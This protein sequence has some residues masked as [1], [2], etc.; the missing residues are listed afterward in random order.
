MKITV[1]LGVSCRWS[2]KPAMKSLHDNYVCTQKVSVYT[3]DTVIPTQLQYAYIRNTEWEIFSCSEY[4]SKINYM[5][6]IPTLQDPPACSELAIHTHQ[7]ELGSWQSRTALSYVLSYIRALHACQ[8]NTHRS[9]SPLTCSEL[10]KVVGWCVS[11]YRANWDPALWCS[12]VRHV[13]VTQD[14]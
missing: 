1:A 3:L 12:H 11:V 9:G 8:E 13:Y 6:R 7:P 5:Y 10:Q 4:T 2:Q 14:L